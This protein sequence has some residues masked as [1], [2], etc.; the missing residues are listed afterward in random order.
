MWFTTEKC[1]GRGTLREELVA[2]TLLKVWGK[3][4]RQNTALLAGPKAFSPDSCLPFLCKGWVES[5]K[6]RHT[7]LQPGGDQH[8]DLNYTINFNNPNLFPPV[9][10]R[11]ASCIP[12]NSSL[13][14]KPK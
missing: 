1:C 9:L 7:P 14:I 6:T 8:H 3:V 5:V 11:H 12:A 13:Y 2:L 10:P 4:V